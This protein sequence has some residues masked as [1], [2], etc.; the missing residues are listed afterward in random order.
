VCIKQK[1]IHQEEIKHDENDQRYEL[2]SSV[3]E[4]NQILSSEEKDWLYRIGEMSCACLK[5]S[6]G[7]KSERQE[8]L[9]SLATILSHML[10]YDHVHRSTAKQ[11]LAYKFV[12]E[13]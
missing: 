1:L 10:Q 8:R 6:T 4:S 9:L 2:V 12:K 5:M 3:I 7:K 13:V 11:L